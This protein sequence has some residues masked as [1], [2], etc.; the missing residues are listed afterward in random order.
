MNA[1]KTKE[2]NKGAFDFS[3]LSAALGNKMPSWNWSSLFL[4]GDIFNLKEP[5]V[6]VGIEM[7]TRRLLSTSNMLDTNPHDDAVS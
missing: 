1:F 6:F 5:V 7:G 4:Q 2:Q 3:L